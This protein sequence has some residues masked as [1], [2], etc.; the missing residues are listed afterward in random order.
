MASPAM[1]VGARMAV[2]VKV[3]LNVG[4]PVSIA[5]IPFVMI[6]VVALLV[7]SS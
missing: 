7:L 4:V 5:E 6:S 1:S 2:K 3:A